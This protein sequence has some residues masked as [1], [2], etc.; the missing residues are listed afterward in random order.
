MQL[1]LGQRRQRACHQHD[2]N[3]ECGQQPPAAG[4]ALGAAAHFVAE[5]TSDVRC[6]AYRLNVSHECMD[7]EFI[8][9]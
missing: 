3:Y 6:S 1:T 8:C 2:A 4:P 9:L 7:T 5:W